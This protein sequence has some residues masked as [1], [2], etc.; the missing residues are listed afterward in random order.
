MADAQDLKSWDLKKSCLETAVEKCG[1][2]RSNSAAPGGSKLI[3]VLVVKFDPERVRLR[4]KTSRGAGC[5]PPARGPPAVEWFL[6]SPA[7]GSGAFE[8]LLGV[9][10]SITGAVG[11]QDVNPVG[12][13]IQERPSQPLTPQHLGPLFKG[14]VGRHDQAGAL[15]SPA[16]DVEQQLS[17]RFGERDV[18]RFVQ[19]DEVLPV[20]LLLER[21]K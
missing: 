10:Q 4:D 19:Q 12:Q 9:L 2:W 7:A 14:Q 15:V 13:T 18:T 1:G 8:S 5:E 3:S 21:F 6:I 16:D 11:F 17:S 20:Q